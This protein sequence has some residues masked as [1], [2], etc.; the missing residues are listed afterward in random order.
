MGKD[1][2]SHKGWLTSDRFY[3]RALAVFGYNVAT[4]LSI[5]IAVAILVF[6][7]YI[8]ALSFPN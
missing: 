2:Y 6:L 7:V 8:I 5:Y 1:T 3:K 4:T